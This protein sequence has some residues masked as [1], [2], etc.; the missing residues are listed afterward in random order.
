MSTL[1]RKLRHHPFQKDSCASDIYVIPAFTSIDVNSIL[2]STLRLREL[3]HSPALKLSCEELVELN[4]LK[5]LKNRKIS[6]VIYIY[7][8][9]YKKF[10]LK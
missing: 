3:I 10:N 1:A 7:R 2:A 4:A 5:P 8:G 9:K 6:K